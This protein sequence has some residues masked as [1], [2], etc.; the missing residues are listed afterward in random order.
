MNEGAKHIVTKDSAGNSL[1]GEKNY[2]LHLPP[3]MPACN[4]W[5]VIVYDIET[6][7]IISTDQP[8][9]S[10]HSNCKKLHVNLDGSMEVWFGPTAPAAR[11]NNWIQT[12]PG[13]EWNMILRLYEPSEPFL[14]KTFIPGKIE[15]IK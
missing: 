6:G 13:K 14:F 15:L 11:E 12:I 2:R 9:P 3:G 4:F 5:S 7:L 10:V 1:T 8:W